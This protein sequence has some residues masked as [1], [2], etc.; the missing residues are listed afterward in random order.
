V[1]RT[2]SLVR[3]LANAARQIAPLAIRSIRS[4]PTVLLVVTLAVAGFAYSAANQPPT[5]GAPAPT[6]TIQTHKNISYG[7]G[8]GCLY[9]T[10]DIA[11]NAKGVVIAVTLVSEY[12]ADGACSI[13]QLSSII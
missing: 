11:T 2:N 7:Y 4:N 12:Y 10:W 8:P 9:Q 6:S 5:T 3:Q 13:D 1:N